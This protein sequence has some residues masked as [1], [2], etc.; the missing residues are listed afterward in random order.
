MAYSSPPADSS[1]HADLSVVD[2][3]RRL[4]DLHL[5]IRP[6]RWRLRQFAAMPWPRPE[7]SRQ[8]PFRGMIVYLVS[9]IVV[10]Q[11]DQPLLCQ[12]DLHD[13]VAGSRMRGLRASIKSVNS[14]VKNWAVSLNRK[15]IQTRHMRPL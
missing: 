6:P 10:G 15:T 8:V 4:P 5:M 2:M 11:R 3:M 12:P 13:R 14:V 1:A 9:T 7:R